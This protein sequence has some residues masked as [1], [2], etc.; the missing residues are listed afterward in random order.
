MRLYTNL[1]E[2]ARGFIGENAISK[3]QLKSIYEI[4]CF[5]Q[6][7]AK[8]NFADELHRLKPPQQ[9]HHSVKIA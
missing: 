8:S 4:D 9:N 3:K 1:L 7:Y 2:C 6:P 5:N